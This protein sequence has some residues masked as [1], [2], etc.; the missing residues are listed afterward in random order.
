MVDELLQATALQV[1]TT[2]LEVE[3]QDNSNFFDLG[4]HS[5]YALRI[6]ALLEERTQREIP[7]D[8]VFDYPVFSDYAVA[9]Q[10]ILSNSVARS[11]P[12]PI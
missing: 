7:I 4:G 10:T 6:A 12:K 5:F 8:L 11:D 3:I 9:L 2:V 1:W